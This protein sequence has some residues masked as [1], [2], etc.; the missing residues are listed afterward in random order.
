MS[1]PP[2]P[3]PMP[4]AERDPLAEEIEMKLRGVDGSVRASLVK[5]INKLVE[6]NPQAFVSNMRNW[7]NQGRHD[8]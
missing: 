3:A 6:K 5:Q 1:R 7:L 4:T 2:M 8:D